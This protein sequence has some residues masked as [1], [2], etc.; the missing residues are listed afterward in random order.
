MRV[1]TLLVVDRQPAAG[2]WGEQILS[3]PGAILPTAIPGTVGLGVF[4]EIEVEPEDRLA[5][6]LDIWIYVRPLD[7]S[8]HVVDELIELLHV[9]DQDVATVG[10][11]AEP[12]HQSFVRWVP[13]YPADTPRQ[14][15]FEARL[16]NVPEAERWISL[17]PEL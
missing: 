5:Q 9:V 7:T 6:Q 10:E 15:W 2:P 12:V 13:R 3:V 14:L 17:V 11:I 1:A 8:L 4:I 16:N